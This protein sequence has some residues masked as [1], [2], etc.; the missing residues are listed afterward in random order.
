MKIKAL[1]FV[2]VIL[3]TAR[4]SA[5]PVLLRYQFS[6]GD[7][8]VYALEADGAGQL[9]TSLFKSANDSK[10]ADVNN[11][12]I[13]LKVKMALQTDVES[14]N[15][16]KIASLLTRVTAFRLVQDGEDVINLKPDSDGGIGGKDVPG[17]LKT[18]YKNPIRMEVDSRGMVKSISGLE[19]LSESL[20]QMDVASLFEQTQHQLPEDA[21]DVGDEWTQNLRLNLSDGKSSGKKDF[22]TK[23]K[24]VGYEN[25]KDLRCAKIR[26]QGQGDISDVLKS[27]MGGIPAK[28]LKVENM[29]IGYDGDMYF[30]ADEGV[31]VALDFTILQKVAASM[32]VKMGN[33]NQLVKIKLD[34]TL[35]GFYEIE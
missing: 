4:A 28:N 13:S 1:I 12:P 33:D 9:T 31:L 27:I 19:K 22:K 5:E 35:N 24:F 14:V 17:T 8:L 26:V 15:K 21:V 6:P 3:T 2:I 20:P 32:D 30:A 18:L 16:E 25:V 23:Y 34:L 11:M 7:I 29:S 10:P